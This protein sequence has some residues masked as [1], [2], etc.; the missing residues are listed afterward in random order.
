MMAGQ[1]GLC[2][3]ECPYIDRSLQILVLCI[4]LPR[5]SIGSIS[6]IL[7]LKADITEPLLL[8]QP[9][10]AAGW[11]ELRISTTAKGRQNGGK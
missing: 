4:Y 3:Q 6:N 10:P 9:P 7:S 11:V 2:F 5:T 8:P 1:M